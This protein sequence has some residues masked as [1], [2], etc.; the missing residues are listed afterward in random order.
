MSISSK[1]I[2]VDWKRFVLYIPRRIANTD[3]GRN[4][5]LFSP[6]RQIGR[7]FQEKKAM[8]HRCISRPLST[9]IP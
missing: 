7:G 2:L 8:R 5:L 9:N 4:E 6:Y 3:Q 1:P